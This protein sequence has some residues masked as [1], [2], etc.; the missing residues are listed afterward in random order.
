MFQQKQEGFSVLWKE[1]NGALVQREE[2]SQQT[3]V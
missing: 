3:V 1:S 2:L